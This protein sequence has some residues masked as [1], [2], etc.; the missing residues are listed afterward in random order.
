[1][2]KTKLQYSGRPEQGGELKEQHRND[3]LQSQGSGAGREKC[4]DS[5][6]DSWVVSIFYFLIFLVLLCRV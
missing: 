3:Y 6:K 1:M 5:R 2:E 4:E